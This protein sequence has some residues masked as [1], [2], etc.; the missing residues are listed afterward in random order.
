MGMWGAGHGIW[1]RMSRGLESRI[2]RGDGVFGQGEKGLSGVGA[3][4]MAIGL[5]GWVCA[6]GAAV[7]V[8]THSLARLSLHKA[9]WESRRIID[10][11]PV[12]LMLRKARCA[13]EVCLQQL[14]AI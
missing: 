2:C 11:S 6:S 14:R 8:R 7:L 3:P 4:R 13:P 5:C 1:M 9:R 10:A 12:D